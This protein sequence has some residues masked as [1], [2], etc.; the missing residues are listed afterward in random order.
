M[1]RD[2]LRRTPVYILASGTS[3][4]INIDPGQVRATR[5][6]L[7]VPNYANAVTT[8]LSF[9]NANGII[10]FT[11]AAHARNANYSIPIDLELVGAYTMRLTLS[12]AAGGSTLIAY[13][14]LFG[15]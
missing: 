3:F 5:L 11:S 13:V 10:V 12:G 7:E 9:I 2:V 4:D 15:E 6:I 14:T 1:V 8:T